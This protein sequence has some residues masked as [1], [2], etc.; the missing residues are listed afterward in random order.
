MM[1]EVMTVTEIIY[2]T[3]SEIS[4]LFSGVA[5]LHRSLTCR[6]GSVVNLNRVY[7]YNAQV[8]LLL[9]LML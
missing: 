2:I 7:R 5:F 3:T 6:G 1:L 4:T 8:Y 9:K